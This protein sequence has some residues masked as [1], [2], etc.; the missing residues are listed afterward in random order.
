[1]LNLPFDLLRNELV[2]TLR[3]VP[4]ETIRE[5]VDVWLPLLGWF[6]A[7]GSPDGGPRQ[8]ADFSGDHHRHPSRRP[9]LRRP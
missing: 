8:H 7:A 2:M 5:I 3:P 6:E 1:M 9:V 4:P